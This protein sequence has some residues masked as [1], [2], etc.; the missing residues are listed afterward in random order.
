MLYE[1]LS[2]HTQPFY[3]VR[4]AGK[5]PHAVSGQSYSKEYKGDDKNGIYIYT[6]I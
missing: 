5:L 1:L 4:K 2:I 3:M 6:Y